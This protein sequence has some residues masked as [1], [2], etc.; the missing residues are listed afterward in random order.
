MRH[1]GMLLS[2]MPRNVIPHFP[3]LA[4][5]TRVVSE[6]LLMKKNDRVIVYRSACI[7][8][9]RSE[10][11]S[12]FVANVQQMLVAKREKSATIE[13]FFKNGIRIFVAGVVGIR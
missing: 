4:A 2:K 11:A 1:Y 6:R 12:E 13:G 5:H 3:L 8:L 10:C 7:Y 9:F